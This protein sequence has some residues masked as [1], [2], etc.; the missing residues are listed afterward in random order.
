MTTKIRKRLKT[1][2]GP[3][4]G[5]YANIK[6]LYGIKKVILDIKYLQVGMKKIGIIHS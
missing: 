6:N 2:F 5:S 3:G 1:M 4:Q